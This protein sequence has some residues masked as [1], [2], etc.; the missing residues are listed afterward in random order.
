MQNFLKEAVKMMQHQNLSSLNLQPP[1]VPPGL[2]GQTGD[3]LAA[4]FLMQAQ[5]QAQ[6]AAQKKSQQSGLTP[7]E[8]QILKKLG[9]DP[10]A[11]KQAGLDPKF[12]VHLANMD[13]KAAVDPKLCAMMMQKPDFPGSQFPNQAVL[14]QA[15]L[16]K[17]LGLFPG[18]APSPALLSPHQEPNLPSNFMLQYLE[19]SHASLFPGLALRHEPEESGSVREEQL[20]PLLS[21]RTLHQLRQWNHRLEL[22]VRLELLGFFDFLLVV[23]GRN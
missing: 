14:H 10:E 5:A 8:Q 15:A 4:A 7:F 2:L 1:L 21:C 6:L 11:V 20:L 12:L 17:Q 9:I 22:Q 19:L 13:P 18:L 16:D 23:G 3:Q